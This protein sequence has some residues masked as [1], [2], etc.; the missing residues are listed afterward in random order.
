MKRRHRL[1]ISFV[2]ALVSIALLAGCIGELYTLEKG[3]LRVG[4]S[5]GDERFSMKR[6]G[7]IEGFDV[8]LAREIA[9]RLGLE[10]ELVPSAWDWLIPG[11]LAESFDIIM[12]GMTMTPTREAEIDFVG[13]YLATDQAVV[14]NVGSPVR[15]AADLRGSRVAVLQESTSLEAARNIEGIAEVL[16]FRDNDD[17]YRA[18][19]AGKADALI[20]DECIARFETSV[21]EGT[22]IVASIKTNER[23]GI[24]VTDGDTAL[25]EDVKRKLAGI[26]AD[27]TY[28]KIF[29]RWFGTT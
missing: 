14:V 11:L 25:A 4:I 2:S 24:G 3:K 21:H 26:M 10:L 27:G 28:M 8:D 6:G 9:S 16:E 17:C 12:S 19:A 7:R 15:S 1:L 20:R 18:L 23:Y 29:T 13:P 22:K 5:P